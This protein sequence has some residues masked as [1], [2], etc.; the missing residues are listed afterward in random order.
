M[1]DGAGKVQGS[2]EIVNAEQAAAWDGQDGDD[3]TEHEEQYNASGRRHTSR[4]I[5]AAQIRPSDQIL[6]V[7][8]G[9]G[10]STRRAARIAVD[11]GA[12]GVDLS[13][14]MLARARERSQAEGV[15]NARFE[16]GDAQ[17]YLFDA[18][19][20]DLSIS[21]FGVMFFGDPVAAFQ[22]VRRALRPGGRI[23]FLTWQP[24][25][26]NE[27]ML[28]IQGA[29]AAGRDLPRPPAGAPGP[30][31]LSDLD[32]VQ[33]IFAEAGF[34]DVNLQSVAEPI[35]LGVDAED[36][37]AFVR[38]LGVTRGMLRD[39]DADTAARALEALRA[40][41]DAHHTGE[42]VR[43]GSAAWLITGRRS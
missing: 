5:D 24:L 28:E 19:A 34:E 14:R 25:A 31:G 13:S 8:C 26:R 2:I 30:F 41:I 9:C 37:F 10:E 27:W 35:T 3:W 21:R 42:G 6:D 7:G 43:F 36:A 38:S 18:D 4:L 40:T 11:G 22:N 32:A 12:L 23:A 17:V 33:R 29:L 16:R 1:A 20:F 39:V 15:T